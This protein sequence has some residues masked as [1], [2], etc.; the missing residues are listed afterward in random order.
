MLNWTQT[1]VSP[2]SSLREVLCTIDTA[3]LQIALV[4]DDNTRLLGLIT[5]GDVRR[6]L[7]KVQRSRH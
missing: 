3:E 1:F 4:V 5:D 6:A 2:E 7:L